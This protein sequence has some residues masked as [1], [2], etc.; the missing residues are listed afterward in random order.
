MI[1][2][3]KFVSSHSSF[4]RAVLPLGE[5]FIRTMNRSLR[6]VADPYPSVFPS[7][8]NAA[9][10][11]LGFRIFSDL[12]RVLL[13]NADD[14]A[15]DAP[16]IITLAASTQSHIEKLGHGLSVSSMT[17]EERIEAIEIARQLSRHFAIHEPG[18]ELVTRPFFRGCGI[19]HACEGD[20]LA[21]T[22]LYEVKNVDR[23][24][25]LA[26][27]R[28]L[29]TYVAL[30]A[31]SPAYE[32]SAVAL[33]NVRSGKFFRIGLN[34]L[35]LAVAG[36]SAPNLLSEVI[37]YLSAESTYVAAERPVRY[38]SGSNP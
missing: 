21:G 15:A 20:V 4:W 14:S 30:N 29:L 11:E 17:R 7:H 22:V 2:E 5:S 10:S 1:S 28:Q 6:K 37:N 19:L 26:D 24:F 35:S 36:F 31:A 13:W 16:L 33:L 23:P 12:N 27:L 32:I 25:R 3:K 8:R 9:I 34:N 38:T 18:Q